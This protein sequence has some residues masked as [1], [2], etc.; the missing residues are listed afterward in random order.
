VGR[1]LCLSGL[2]TLK[3]YGI[4][5]LPYLWRRGVGGPRLVL[6][7]LAG[8]GLICAPFILWS[9]GFKFFQDIVFNFQESGGRYDSL[10]FYA[11]THLWGDRNLGQWVPWAVYGVVTM[12]LL[13]RQPGALRAFGPAGTWLLASAV[14]L[15]WF[16]LFA[17][18]CF[19][20]YQW[21]GSNVVLL[22]LSLAVW[23]EGSPTGEEIV[24]GLPS[25]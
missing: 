10:S 15:L 23:R 1:A 7:G 25:T 3:Q 24:K 12:V 5:W 20:N 2:L 18:Q 16:F 9:P 22:A 21:L 13:W 14:G 17:K 6:A 4:L 8:A 11:A 19:I